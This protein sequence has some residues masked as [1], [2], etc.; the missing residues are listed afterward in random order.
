MRSKTERRKFFSTLGSRLRIP[1]AGILAAVSLFS[2]AGLGQESENGPVL[3]VFRKGAGVVTRMA[4]RT[5]AVPTGETNHELVTG[6]F[7]ADGVQDA[8]TFDP[9]SRLFVIR[10]SG[11]GS[12]LAVSAPKAKGKPV[13]ASADFDGDKRTDPAVWRAGTWQIMLSSRDYA[14]DVAI[15]G[16]AGDVPVPADF[17]GDSR[18]DLAVF[19]SSENRWYVQSSESGKV[20]TFDFGVA[21]IDLL[22]PADYTGDGKADAA[23]YRGGVWHLIDSDTGERETFEFGFEDARPVPGDFNRDGAV[24]FAVYRKGTW[25]VYD[26]AGLVSHK[27]GGDEDVP[28][29]SVAVRASVPGR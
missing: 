3:S 11:D 1:T 8:G 27:F 19:R 7:D 20:R 9:A 18:A 28:L 13:A 2:T 16:I 15:F 6:D 17:D 14:A 12:T 26:G 10:R 25:Y 4:G 5:A 22:L 24:D 23:F 29:G 21:G